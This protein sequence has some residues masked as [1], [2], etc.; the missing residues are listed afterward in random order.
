MVGQAAA[1][2]L[3]LPATLLCKLDCVLVV[4]Q[5]GGAERVEGKLRRTVSLGML[6]NQH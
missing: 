2:T 4:C 1:G 6:T 3:P 5:L